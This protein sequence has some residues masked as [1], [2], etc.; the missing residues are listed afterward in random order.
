M[1][2]VRVVLLGPPG[3]GKGTQAKS[4]VASLGVP[5]ISSGD[6]LR[7]A[8]TGL[9]ELGLEAR[10]Y[11]DVGDL[12]PDELVLGM[13]EKRIGGTDCAPGFLLDGFPRTQAQAAALGD[14]LNARGGPLEH[15]VALAVDRTEVVERLAGRRICPDCGRLYHV[16]FE[17]PQNEGRCDD[18]GTELVVRDDDREETVRQPSGQAQLPGPRGKPTHQ[19]LRTHNLPGASEPAQELRLR[20]PERVLRHPGL[21]SLRLQLGRE[22]NIAAPQHD[23]A[24]RS[25]AL[26]ARQ[27][28]NPAPIGAHR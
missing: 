14:M 13:I 3:A 20:P 16:R 28:A 8:V 6:L 11:M 15:V 2:E 22:A 12:V 7:E 10:S 23:R 26:A 1:S 24:P 25:A 21:A 18:C 17:A 19:G 5:H 4:L 9:T 27:P